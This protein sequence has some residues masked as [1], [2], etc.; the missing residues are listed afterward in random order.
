[1][2]APNKILKIQTCKAN[3]KCMCLCMRLVN[4]Y[5]MYDVIMYVDMY[6]YVMKNWMA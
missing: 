4:S 2:C 1:M 5:T 3:V 6:L